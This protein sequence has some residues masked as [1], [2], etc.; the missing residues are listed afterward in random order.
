MSSTVV[1]RP[2]VDAD[3]PAITE[4]YGWNV[5]NGFGTF[6]EVPPDEAEMAR[7]REGFLS[8]GLPYLVAELDGKVVGYAYAGPF[9]LRA[10]YRYTVED[11]IYVSPDAVGSG[12]G[13][14]LLKTLIEAC[15]ALGLRQMCAVIGDSGNQAS[16]ALHAALGFEKKGVF[17]DMGHKFGRWLDLVWMQRPLNGGGATP[18]DTPGMSL[19]GV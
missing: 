17:P 1:I 18:P 7:R 15:E 2:S 19:N 12:V 5:L 6:E 13:R 3:V 11:S 4:I 9:R 8:R 16:I 10:A 14:A